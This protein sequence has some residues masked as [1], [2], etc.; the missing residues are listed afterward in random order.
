MLDSYIVSAT[1]YEKLRKKYDDGSW[2]RARFADAHIL[3]PGRLDQYDYMERMF[4]NRPSGS[5][6]TPP[7]LNP[8]GASR[9][10]KG[11]IRT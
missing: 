10:K 4:E 7:W 8:M 9:P 5:S 6:S 2:D 3:F 11:G 1:P